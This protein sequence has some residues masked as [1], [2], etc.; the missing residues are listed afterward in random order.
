MN[1]VK[2][3]THSISWRVP[4]FQSLYPLPGGGEDEERYK[5][6]IEEARR[7]KNRN[8]LSELTQCSEI[9]AETR[10]CS[11]AILNFDAGKSALNPSLLSGT[12]KLSWRE[13][14]GGSLDGTVLRL[15]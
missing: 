14:V 12:N 1:I 11:S 9:T 2:E 10:L 6:R 5:A 13:L 7:P 4:P 15:H 3:D 8:T